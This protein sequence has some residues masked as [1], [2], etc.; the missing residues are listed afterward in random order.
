LFNADKLSAGGT[1]GVAIGVVAGFG[2]IVALAYFYVMP[3]FTK[4]PLAAA[5]QKTA[6]IEL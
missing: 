5:A 4:A 3:M 2:A 6:D 1:A